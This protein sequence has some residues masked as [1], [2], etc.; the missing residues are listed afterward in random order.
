MPQTRQIIAPYSPDT[1]GFRGGHEA[2]PW[3][4]LLHQAG[5]ALSL[6][7]TSI[8]DKPGPS[9]H[10]FLAGRGSLSAVERESRVWQD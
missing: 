7:L 9:G 2:K 1:D 5:K 6:P 3:A 10:I 4:R 8:K